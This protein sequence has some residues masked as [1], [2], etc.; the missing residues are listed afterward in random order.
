MGESSGRRALSMCS[1]AK[2]RENG[3]N[4][5]VIDRSHHGKAN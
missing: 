5:A 2:K 4:L 3:R 1:S